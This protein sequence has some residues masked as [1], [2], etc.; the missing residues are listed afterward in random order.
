MISSFGLT[1]RTT[2]AFQHLNTTNLMYS[3]RKINNL[4]STNAATM[5]ESSPYP[6]FQNSGNNCWLGSKS[7]GCVHYRVK[8]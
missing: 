4:S 2:L 8:G 7:T 5:D 6:V 1:L 3:M